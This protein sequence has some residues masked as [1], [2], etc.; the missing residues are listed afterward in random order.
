M[1]GDSCYCIYEREAAVAS[2]SVYNMALAYLAATNSF[3]LAITSA[4]PPSS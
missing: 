4:S 2:L 3:T 1:V